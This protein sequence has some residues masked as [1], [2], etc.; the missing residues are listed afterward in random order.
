[1]RILGQ[2]RSASSPDAFIWLRGFPDHESRPA[3]LSR[4]YDGPAWARW[5]AAANATMADSDN[6]IVLRPLAG[7]DRHPVDPWARLD[8]RVLTLGVQRVSS[9]AHAELSATLGQGRVP[10]SLCPG[11]IALFVSEPAA[12][13]WPR[14][15]VRD[16]GPFFA[17]LSER[18]TLL[19]SGDP[20]GPLTRLVTS[21]AGTEPELLDLTPTALSLRRSHDV[22]EQPPSGRAR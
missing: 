9:D 14:L 6:V 8:R 11:L 22:T 16:D 12:N 5:A 1:M 19:S 4:F 21:L 13:N 2:F 18:P 3:A 15:P 17:W 10:A 7:D 20:A